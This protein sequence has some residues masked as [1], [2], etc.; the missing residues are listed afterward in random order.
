ME[1]PTMSA[2]VA[3]HSLTFTMSMGECRKQNV[4]NDAKCKQV[5][6]AQTPVLAV[7]K[8]SDGGYYFTKGESKSEAKKKGMEACERRGNVTCTVD[9]VYGSGGGLFEF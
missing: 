4:G 2:A 1:K 9:K 7:I 6:D 3:L 5:Y 8:S